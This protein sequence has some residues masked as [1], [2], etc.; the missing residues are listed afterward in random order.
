MLTLAFVQLLAA[1]AAGWAAM[2]VLKGRDSAHV[3]GHLRLSVLLTTAA[4]VVAALLT[5]GS[6]VQET[7]G[8]AMGLPSNAKARARQWLAQHAAQPLSPREVGRNIRILADGLAFYEAHAASFPLDLRARMQEYARLPEQPK[9]LLTPSEENRY[10]QAAT[11]L[12]HAIRTVAEDKSEQPFPR[13][14]PPSQ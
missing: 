4:A 12:V 1:A 2:L 11:R 6:V 5:L 3:S 9:R 8:I 13:Q 7:T 14:E 10:Y